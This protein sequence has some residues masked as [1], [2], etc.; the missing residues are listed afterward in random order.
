[1]HRITD[2]RTIAPY[3]LLVEFDHS[4]LRWIDLGFKLKEWSEGDVSTPF[5]QLLDFKE[6]KKVEVNPIAKTLVW[7]NGVDF[8][9]DILYQWSEKTTAGYTKN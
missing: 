6:F 2:I 8:C 3:K 1:M 7:L 5:A 9:P 4:E